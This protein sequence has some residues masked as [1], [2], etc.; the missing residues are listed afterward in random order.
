MM[1]MGNLL[2]EP[3]FQALGWSLLH[4]V[5]QG[6]IVAL[7]LATANF[8]FRRSSA[9]KRYLLA[10]GALLLMAAL[11]I[12]TFVLIASELPSRANVDN[13]VQTSAANTTPNEKPKS[14]P[15]IIKKQISNVTTNKESIASSFSQQ[16]VKLYLA[17]VM[18]YFVTI[19]LVGVFLLSVR[20]IGGW[21]LVQRLKKKYNKEV[22]DEWKESLAVLAKRLRVSRPVSLFESALTEVPTAIGWF[23]PVI[24][25]PVGTLAGLSPQQV[26]ALLAHELAHIRRYDYLV[27]LLQTIIETVLFYH[28]AVWWVS[29]QIRTERENCCDDLAVAACGNV[30]TYARALTDLEG[31]RHNEKPQLAMAADG[32]SLSFR[33][34]RLLGLPVPQR[35]S[36]AWLASLFIMTALTLTSLGASGLIAKAGTGAKNFVAN[37]VLGAEKVHSIQSHTSPTVNRAKSEAG[38]LFGRFK[39]FLAPPQQATTTTNDPVDVPDEADD[40]DMPVVASVPSPNA[41]PTPTPQSSQNRNRNEDDD[42]ESTDFIDELAA[43]GYKNLKVDDLVAMKIHGVTGKFIREM[44]ELG[45]NLDVDDLVSFRI[46]GVTPEYI[47]EMRKT[48]GNLDADDLVGMKIHGVTPEY[49]SQ[50]GS[51]VGGTL[52]IDELVAFRIHGVTPE[53]IKSLASM[54]FTKLDADE[55]V[56]VRVHNLTPQYIQEMQNAGFGKLSLEQLLSLRIHGIT[57]AFI[58]KVKEKGFTDLTINQVVQLKNLGILRDK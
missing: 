47:R 44:R 32:G 22:S 19:W 15:A 1:T 24:L 57:P 17:A 54:G 12:A 50:M 45:F 42:E 30:L 33:V 26:E 6:A 10:C 3:Y 9:N 31:L 23:R 53:L 29:N 14:L 16:N 39:K 21:L 20:A 28:P 46:H 27:N 34:R 56:S 8:A 49:A 11:P 18:P 5:W 13:T 52:K 51:L 40:E 7:L 38:S 35:R 55:L 43:A 2:T 37:K 58:K 25:V 36:T 4:F 41:L 48:F